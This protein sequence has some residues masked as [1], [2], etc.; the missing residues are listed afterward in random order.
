MSFSADKSGYN[1]AVQTKAVF[2]VKDDLSEGLLYGDIKAFHDLSNR[3]KSHIK[4]DVLEEKM[5]S[6]KDRPIMADIVYTGETD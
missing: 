3:N 1:I 2:E 4:T 6:I 5:M